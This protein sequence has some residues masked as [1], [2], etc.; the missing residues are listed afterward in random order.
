MHPG[1]HTIN[2]TEYIPC[3]RKKRNDFSHYNIQ[4]FPPTQSYHL[5]HPQ[6]ASR[7][8]LL[9]SLSPSLLRTSQP[10]AQIQAQTYPQPYPQPL[11]QSCSKSYSSPSP[12]STP[13]PKHKI[14]F[15]T[16]QVLTSQQKSGLSSA[17]DMKATGLTTGFIVHGIALLLVCGL[18]VGIDKSKAEGKKRVGGEGEEEG[19]NEYWFFGMF[20]WRKRKGVEG[21][22]AEKVKKRWRIRIGDER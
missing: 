9:S 7:R 8:H 12:S 15:H 17:R 21:G 10:Q 11:H 16:N 20:V 22:E 14:E 3:T 2:M 6:M 19:V 1:P 4:K 13:P 5:T 18:V